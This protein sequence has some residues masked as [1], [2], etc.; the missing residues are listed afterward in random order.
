MVLF[1]GVFVLSR[2]V[3]VV[4]RVVCVLFC[5]V[6]MVFRAVL[7]WCFVLFFCDISCCFC[8]VSCCFCAVCCCFE[9]LL[10]CSVPFLRCHRPYFPNWRLETRAARRAARLAAFRFQRGRLIG[11]P[12]P[13]TPCILRV[14]A[15]GKFV[16]VFRLR[17]DQSHGAAAWMFHRARRLQYF[18]RSGENLR[19]HSAPG[20][21]HWV[22]Y[23][24][25]HNGECQRPLSQERNGHG[26]AKF[27]VIKLRSSLLEFLWRRDGGRFV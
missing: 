7:L 27:L 4:F 3:F 18:S 13:A 17:N 2:G 25:A 23:L 10:W 19:R 26:S 6:F 11:F 22:A 1:R 12:P 5:A 20:L 16:W 15:R 21:T 24:A 14:P 8:L 9:L